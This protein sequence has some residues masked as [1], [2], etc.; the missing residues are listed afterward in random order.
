MI[1]INH[2]AVIEFHVCF[3]VSVLV[4][5]VRH[6]FHPQLKTSGIISFAQSPRF[7]KLK[8]STDASSLFCVCIS[9]SGKLTVMF[10]AL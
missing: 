1:T 8:L 4:C 10:Y 9:S 6:L 7:M 2:L 3:L 5:R